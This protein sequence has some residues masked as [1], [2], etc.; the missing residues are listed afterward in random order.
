MTNRTAALMA[1]MM[2][3]TGV[4][5]TLPRLAVAADPVIQDLE[6]VI[7]TAR[8][9]DEK[10]LDVPDSITV[11]TSQTLVD[12]GA[13]GFSDIAALAPNMTFSPGFRPGRMSMTLRGISTPSYGDPPVALVIDGVQIPSM[14]FFN[15]DLFD[16]DSVEV[17]KGPQ[18]ALYGRGAIGG[19]LLV[20]T[21]PTTDELS[22]SF[23]A[24]AGNGQDRR[25]VGSLSGPL[26]GDVWKSR[27]AVAWSDRDGLIPDRSMGRNAD[28][29]RQ[30][31]VRW[32]NDFDLGKNW[33]LSVRAEGVDS[34]A[35]A[36]PVEVV[37]DTTRLDY[38]VAPNRDMLTADDRTASALSTRLV[39]QGNSFRFDWVSAYFS[40]DSKLRGDADFG[41]LSIAQQYNHVTVDSLSQEV[42]LTSADGGPLRWL[43][44]AF[45]QHQNNHD[46]LLVDGVVGGPLPGV[47]LAH[48]DQHNASTAWAAFAQASYDLTKK[49]EL[50]GALRFDSDKRDSEDSLQ[51]GSAITRTFT[52][53]Q[54]KVSLKYKW[55]PT[56]MTYLSA[57]RGFLSG[58]FNPY[59]DSITQG[60][61]RLYPKEV[62][63][64]GEA[65]AKFRLQNGRLTLNVA[66]FRT[67][68]T[69]QQFYFI[70]LAN[71]TRSTISIHKTTIDG[72]EVDSSW[73]PL[74]G[75]TLS[76]SIGVMKNTIDDYD[77]T[78]QYRGKR[79][80]NTFAGTTSAA[81]QYTQPLG[82]AT[83][84]TVRG[85]YDHTGSIYYDLPNQYR[86]PAVDFVGARITLDHNRWSFVAY[87]R[88]LADERTPVG[89]G[90]TA[91]A[92]AP[93]V[94]IRFSNQPRSYGMEVRYVFAGASR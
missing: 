21:R 45:Y 78:A 37:T 46:Y 73:M 56:V 16:I 40:S 67:K 53:P 65:G 58:S 15:Q 32:V 84:L 34:Y 51:P 54:P 11:V 33:T 59:R 71:A 19:A 25:L 82:D 69:D 88:N 70:N 38:S 81:A 10:L 7:V 14:E 72:G 9:R 18:G 41:P 92:F 31:S 4:F 49:L 60:I 43:A 52:E 50:T 2:T 87:G 93:G 77:G 48:S 64:T 6:E 42:R 3:S 62:S 24:S 30:A 26:P 55:T 23:L 44:G 17:V 36:S 76:A 61:P 94:H 68:F 83:S 8:M 91:N 79:S 27:L 63:D 47:V 75:L 20:S 85:Q 12:V 89:F 13:R 39:F 74:R 90:F 1:A 86:F 57:G 29:G 28:F 66:V 80:P 35:G 5:A 22:G